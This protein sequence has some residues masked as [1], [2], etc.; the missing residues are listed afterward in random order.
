[1]LFTALIK[2]FRNLLLPGVIKI[3]LWCLVAYAAMFAALVWAMAWLIEH[4]ITMPAVEGM[5]ATLLT[6][7]GG[8]LLAWFMFPLLYPIL[9]SFFDEQVVEIIDR[10]D[11]ADQPPAQAPFWPTIGNDLVFT[12][13][14]IGLNI[15]CLPLFFIPPVGLVAYY[16]LNGYLLGTQFFRMAAG[17]RVTREEADK[18]QK[19]N[20]ASIMLTGVVIIFLATVPFVNLAAPILGVAT[21]AHLFYLSRQ[22]A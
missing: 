7:A 5:W 21:M 15:C 12:L 18:L 20:F 4:F 9:V 8:M 19:D 11:Y 6:S 13:K 1:M 16:A 3:F 10:E 2:A 17:R 14:A 22:A